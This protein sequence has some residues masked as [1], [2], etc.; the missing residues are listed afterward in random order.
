V[1][2]LG[3]GDAVADKG[4]TERNAGSETTPTPPAMTAEIS[5]FHVNLR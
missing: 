2:F 1:F 4:A 5:S 3:T